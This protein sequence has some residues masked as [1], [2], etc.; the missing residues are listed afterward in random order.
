MGTWCNMSDFDWVEYIRLQ[1]QNR[2]VIRKSFYLTKTRISKIL[3]NT[4]VKRIIYPQYKEAFDYVGSLYPSVNIRHVHVYHA[5][6]AILN[7]VGYRGVGGF[8]D[9]QSKI[10]CITEWAGEGEYDA[11]NAEYTID[12]V[13]CHEL[14]HFAANAK[15]PLSSRSVEEEIAYGNSVGY[16]RSKGR[17]DQFIV[18][19]NMLPYLLSIVDSG[20]IVKEVLTKYYKNDIA[21]ISTSTVDELVKLHKKE[22]KKQTIEKA[23]EKGYQLVAI[24]GN[25]AKEEYIP[26]AKKLILDDFL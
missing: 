22:I 16:L 4:D 20:E 3:A 15:C 21:R 14:I 23:K 26:P 10:V 7:H 13:L 18:E 19:K 24:Y 12:E 1:N 11:I 9:P 8:Y 6:K 5:T 2:S 25:A 17:S